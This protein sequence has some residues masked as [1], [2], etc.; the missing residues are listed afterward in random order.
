MILALLLLACAPAASTHPCAAY[1]AEPDVFKTCIGRLVRGE[2]KIAIAA[3]WCD[4]LPSPDNVSCRATW[5]SVAAT[6]PDRF[7]GT[8]AD[9]LAFCAG[10]TDCAFFVLDQR[11]EGTVVDQSE[12]C[13]TWTGKM[14]NDCIGHASQRYFQGHPDDA[15]LKATAESKFGSQ[16]L[17]AIV[18]AI[19]CQRRTECPDL[20]ALTAECTRT[21]PDAG[22]RGDARCE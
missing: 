2:P 20:G 21:L 1:E 16:M 7:E 15:S 19:S 9:L 12:A 5:I 6:Q 13:V 11:P 4:Q 22:R 10:A 17:P 3:K 14:A 8:R 18:K